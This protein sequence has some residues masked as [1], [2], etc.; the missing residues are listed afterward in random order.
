[1]EE[2]IKI[3]R[4][5]TKE[6]FNILRENWPYFCE[7]LKNK[8]EITNLYLKHI[9]WESWKRKVKEIILRLLIIPLVWKI[10]RNW[11]IKEERIWV[12]IEWREYKK[13]FKISLEIKNEFFSLIIAK[14]LNDKL[15][16]IS[17]FIDFKKKT[18]TGS[19]PS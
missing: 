8:V 17:S 6:S 4:I 3:T 5:S 7:E 11:K 18:I 10:L 9:S 12:K 14:R 2:I 19:N 13:A 15:V 16:L 1:M